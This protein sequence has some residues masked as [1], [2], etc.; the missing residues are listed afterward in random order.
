MVNTPQKRFVTAEK[1]KNMI[2]FDFDKE[3]LIKIVIGNP[4]QNEKNMFFP[5]V[6]VTKLPAPNIKQPNSRT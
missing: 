2:F 5:V 1:V 4:H 3:I 6:S